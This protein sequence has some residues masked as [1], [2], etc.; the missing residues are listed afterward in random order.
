MK[1][2]LFMM[3]FTLN[4]I[5]LNGLA[6][7]SPAKNPTIDVVIEELEQQL[8]KAR[9]HYAL[10]YKTL[11]LA[12]ASTSQN[13]KIAQDPN[14]LMSLLIQ[15]EGLKDQ[16]ALLQQ[17]E[18][19]NISK[20]R[21]LKG[22][23]IIKIIYEKTLALDHHLSSVSTFNEISNM[24]NPNSYP[25]FASIR[26][27]L[28]SKNNKKVGFNLSGILG[29]NI[30][31][32]VI[33]SFVSIFTANDSSKSE[34]EASIKEVECILDFTLRMH[35]DL[36]TIF[37]ETTFLQQSNQGVIESL[38]QLF[39]DYT[40]PIQYQTALKDCRARDDWDAIKAKLETYLEELNLLLTSPEKQQK[41][42]RMQINLEFPIDRLL[43]FIDQYN[44]FIDQGEKFYQKFAIM[45]N[46]YKTETHCLPKI[47]AEFLTLKEN[48]AVT[49]QKFNTAYKPV[50]IN[51]SKLKEVL[52]GINQFD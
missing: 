6:A 47:P 13:L 26:N 1:I 37:F 48:I 23:E 21:Y 27:I 29:E 36:N 17:K 46:T 9:Q 42:T 8:A 12:L 16:L 28:A 41:I 32:S 2:L 40:K 14:R 30:Y 34:K 31:T 22:L 7:H 25:E 19:T 35:N 51:G 39:I 3:L 5:T 11:Y 24:S 18:M 45:L 44:N 38:D 52:Y 15:K 50:E 20:I 4:P 33:H 49:I 10:E 43:Q